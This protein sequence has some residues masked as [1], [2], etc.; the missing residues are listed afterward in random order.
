M[1]EGVYCCVRVC[2]LSLVICVCIVQL[3]TAQ[4][5]SSQ[6]L[7]D[8]PTTGKSNLLI[9]VCYYNYWGDIFIGTNIFTCFELNLYFSTICTER[10]LYCV[11]FTLFDS[12]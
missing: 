2:S 11:V 10:V 1:C 3:F 8:W 5:L 12:F 6:H 9:T 4:T 7:I